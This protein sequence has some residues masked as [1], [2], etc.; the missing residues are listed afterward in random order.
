MTDVNDPVVAST[1][2]GPLNPPPQV[3]AA[4]DVVIIGGGIVGVSTAWFLAKRGVNVVLCE[5]GHIAGEQSG[6]NWGWVRVQGRDTREIP[7]MQ[8]SLRIWGELKNEIGEDV[9]FTR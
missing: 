5:K 8:E 7:M 6:R 1:W 4:A 9:G 3:P 2:S